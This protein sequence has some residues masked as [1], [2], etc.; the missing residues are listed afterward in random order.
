M[1]ITSGVILSRGVSSKSQIYCPW[2]CLCH[3]ELDITLC[4]LYLTTLV[5]IFQL[6][7]QLMLVLEQALTSSPR[8]PHR[9]P[10]CPSR[11]LPFQLFY[12][13]SSTNI[14]IP[15][16]FT[17]SVLARI[18][19]SLAV[20]IPRYVWLGPAPHNKT[21]MDLITPVTQTPWHPASVFCFFPLSL[22]ILH[23]SSVLVC[24]SFCSPSPSLFSSPLSS[25]MTWRIC[26]S[27]IH[28]SCW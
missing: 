10:L 6:L 13:F 9:A 27:A 26:L 19:S 5:D 20:L 17:C 2:D 3:V 18:V 8:L 16:S 4:H 24:L 11:L 22:S 21:M 25:V 1:P 15:F 28:L 14:L 23:S 12:S 7:H